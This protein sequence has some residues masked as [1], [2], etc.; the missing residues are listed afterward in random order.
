MGLTLV[1][2]SVIYVISSSQFDRPLPPRSDIQSQIYLFNDGSRYSIQDLIEQRAAEARA[3]LILSLI[4][5]NLT[6]LIGGAILSYFLAR[7]TLEPIEQVM[8]AQSQFVSDA[9]HELRTPLTALQVTNEVA[10]RKKK[11]NIDEAKE[12][13]EYNLAETIKLRNISEA[14]LGLAKQQDSSD[15]SREEFDIAP[16]VSSA[17]DSFAPLA[18]DKSITI[19]QEISSKF[20][21]A[22]KPALEH[23]VRILLDNAVKYSPTDSTITIKA[24][25]EDEHV[26]ISV[27][28]EGPGIASEHQTKIFDRFYRV[29]ESRSSQHVEGSGL[30]LAIAKSV[31]VRHEL[32]LSVRSSPGKGAE[33]AVRVSR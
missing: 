32:G 19:N 27:I 20:V 33:F 29:D 18:K 14:L 4:M 23:I 10:L 15:T 9:S 24:I 17:V 22:N 12:L 3:E 28:D 31:A 21:T 25:D 5:L 13:I 16:V 2:S 8:E 7:K 26:V 6:V 30:G 11:L 1:F